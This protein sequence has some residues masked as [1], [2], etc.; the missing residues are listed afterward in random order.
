MFNVSQMTKQLIEE[1]DDVEEEEED[2]DEEEEEKENPELNKYWKAVKENP[3]DFTAW[4][5]L[6]QFV[7]QNVSGLYF[8][9]DSTKY[10]DFTGLLFCGFKVHENADGADRYRNS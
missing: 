4:T 3:T 10:V 1:K 9:E 5:Y 7:E 8:F 6:L 2:D